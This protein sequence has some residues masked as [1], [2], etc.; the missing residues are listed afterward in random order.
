MNPFKTPLESLFKDWLAHRFATRT[1]PLGFCQRASP[2]AG[3]RPSCR[4]TS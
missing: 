1:L 2:F 3:L 4:L